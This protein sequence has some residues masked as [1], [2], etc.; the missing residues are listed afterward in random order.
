MPPP[1]TSPSWHVRRRD[2][3]APCCRDSMLSILSF[4]M[5]TQYRHCGT[6][7]WTRSIPNDP[8]YA[9]VLWAWS[10]KSCLKQQGT[11]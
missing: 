11:G 9:I 1:C 7:H 8:S 3:T 10:H 6:F 4:V 5:I 2:A